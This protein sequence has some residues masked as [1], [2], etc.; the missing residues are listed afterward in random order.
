MYTHICIYIYIY[1]RDSYRARLI[2]KSTYPSTL[3]GYAYG[4]GARAISSK[5]QVLERNSPPHGWA[6]VDSPGILVAPCLG[7]I[8][9]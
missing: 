4:V 5:Q 3:G 1:Y 9:I 8:Y 2:T 7:V 6:L